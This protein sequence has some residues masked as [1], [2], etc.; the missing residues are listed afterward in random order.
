MIDFHKIF[1]QTYL[2]DID[3]LT[4]HRSDK[5][6]F[7][8]G[9]ALV[10]VGIIFR[11]ISWSAK[12][13]FTKALRRRFSTWALTIGLLEALWFGLRYQNTQIL[14]SHLV[15]FLILL[16]GLVWFIYILKYALGQYRRNL[17]QWE[18]DLLKQKYLQR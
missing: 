16:I 15:A 3:Q 18:K 9:G 6:L 8:V 14:G 2:L 5:G 10:I 7:V 17:A 12:N 1:S 4:L 11:L 13:P